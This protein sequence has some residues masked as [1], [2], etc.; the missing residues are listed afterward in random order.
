MLIL[1]MLSY[2]FWLQ[3][4]KVNERNAK[5]ENARALAMMYGY[6]KIVSL[7]DSQSPR[8]K[9]GICSKSPT[10]QHQYITFQLLF[11]YYTT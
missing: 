6:T 4:V 2:I 7:I 5:G 11:T 8:I 3:K 1:Q 10:F 9:L